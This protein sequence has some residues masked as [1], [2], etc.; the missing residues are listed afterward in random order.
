MIFITNPKNVKK[1]KE[2]LKENNIDPE[3]PIIIFHPGSLGSSIDLPIEKFKELIQMVNDKTG[4]QIIFTGSENEKQLCEGLV[5]N[6]SVKNFAGNFSLSEMISLINLS[7]VFISNSTGP[8]HIA[9]ALNKNTIGFYPKILACSAKRWGPYS[10]KAKVFTP[11]TNCKNCDREQ[12]N[13]L[14]CMS[15]INVKNVF[16]EIEKIYM[17]NTN[18]GEI[19]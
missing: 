1:V 19:K 11:E 9:A 13:D 3:K 18:N 17:L 4:F 12:C 2:V 10:V 14:N 16:V 6:N 5:I 7:S 15:S 8:I